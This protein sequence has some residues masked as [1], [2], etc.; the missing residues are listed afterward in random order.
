M[1][2]SPE[3]VTD[4]I[5]LSGPYSYNAPSGSFPD[6]SKP[7]ELYSKTAPFSIVTVLVPSGWFTTFSPSP[8]V[9]GSRSAMGAWSPGTLS[10]RP[11]V[12]ACRLNSELRKNIFCA[13]RGLN[14]FSPILE[15]IRF[16][17]STILFMK[18]GS[19]HAVLSP[20][21]ALAISSLCCRA[22]VLLG[23]YALTSTDHS[24]SVHKPDK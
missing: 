15:S 6:N 3:D 24:L 14:S 22:V 9:S 10:T 8:A 20:W 5:C 7:S 16:I 21:E 2:G 13:A 4:I 12:S 23:L 17:Q 1:V 18:P 11:L 19:S